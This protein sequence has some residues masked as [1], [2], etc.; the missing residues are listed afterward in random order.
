MSVCGVRCFDRYKDG[1]ATDASSWTCV[2]G[3]LCDINYDLQ[4]AESLEQIRIG[5]N[6]ASMLD[7]HHVHTWYHIVAAVEA[8]PPSR[9]LMTMICIRRWTYPQTQSEIHDIRIYTVMF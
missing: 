4:A 8:S 1:D 7:I 6:G 5:E 9:E 2:S 3:E